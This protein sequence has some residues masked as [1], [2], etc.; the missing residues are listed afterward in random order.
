MFFHRKN[1]TKTIIGF[2]SYVAPEIARGEPYTNK[3][4]LWSIG[5]LGYILYFGELPKFKN[6]RTY[7]CEFHVYED[8]NLE[9]LLTK[10]IVAN[11]DKR[12]SW[13]EF[14]MTV[15][16]IQSI[17]FKHGFHAMPT[18]NS[19]FPTLNIPSVL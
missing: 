9:V 11:P 16:V 10:L 13:D 1:Q 12:I 15:L 7:E 6:K 8:Y 3:C 18:V 5:I 17:G 2:S 19:V 14:F 4:D